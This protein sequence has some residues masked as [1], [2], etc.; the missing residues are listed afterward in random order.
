MCNVL[1]TFFKEILKLVLDRSRSCH[2]YSFSSIKMSKTIARMIVLTCSLTI[3]IIVKIFRAQHHLVHALLDTYTIFESLMLLRLYLTN[4]DSYCLLV[5]ARLG[6]LRLP[7]S[8]SPAEHGAPCMES[9][10]QARDG[11]T[12]K[13]SFLEMWHNLWGLA[14]FC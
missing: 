1:H 9:I 7:S 8:N 5:I 3:I 10:F 6:K 13:R 12:E 14:S 4:R 11:E 2:V